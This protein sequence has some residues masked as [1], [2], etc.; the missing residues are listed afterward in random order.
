[1]LGEKTIGISFAVSSIFFLSSSKKP[2]VPITR[3]VF[4]SLA[5]SRSLRVASGSVK[6]ITT[7]GFSGISLMEE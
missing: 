2:V 3:A 6:S 7:S 1:M 4:S 5:S